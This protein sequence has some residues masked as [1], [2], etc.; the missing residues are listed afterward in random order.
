MTDR[1]I[2]DEGYGIAH[3]HY[4]LCEYKSAVDILQTTLDDRYTD[5]YHSLLG[6]VFMELGRYDDAETQFVLA[7]QTEYGNLIQQ[8]NHADY[9]GRSLKSS[10]AKIV[11]KDT[12]NFLAQSPEDRLHA[13]RTTS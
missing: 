10:T 4:R 9:Y 1:G 3:C 8:N 13:I 7:L 11:Q 5:G 12:V 2:S 6:R